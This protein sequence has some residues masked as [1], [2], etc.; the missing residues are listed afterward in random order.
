MML[1]TLEFELQGSMMMPLK[2]LSRAR[3]EQVQA[4]IEKEQQEH[5]EA[6]EWS[7]QGK[8]QIGMVLATTDGWVLFQHTQISERRVKVHLPSWKIDGGLPILAEIWQAMGGKDFPLTWNSKI[9]PTWRHKMQCQYFY[10]TVDSD[11]RLEV[12]MDNR[13]QWYCHDDIKKADR[14]IPRVFK[15]LAA[16]AIVTHRGGCKFRSRKRKQARKTTRSGGRAVEGSK[17][18]VAGESEGEEGEEALTAAHGTSS[19]QQGQRLCQC[20]RQV[21]S[22]VAQVPEIKATEN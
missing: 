9:N 1:R 21:V 8:L 4:E 2:E 15:E 14:E 16:A 19:E 10:Y 5:L 20:P 3:T 11:A 12:E 7:R 17:G 22:E 18:E 6:V 13:W